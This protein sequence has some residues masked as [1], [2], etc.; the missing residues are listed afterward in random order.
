M[1]RPKLSLTSLSFFR[2]SGSDE[3]V[4]CS[5]SSLACKDAAL[6]TATQAPKGASPH[7]QQSWTTARLQTYDVPPRACV[8]S[9]WEQPCPCHIE[10]LCHPPPTD[11]PISS[12]TRWSWDHPASLPTSGCSS[13]KGPAV[14][15]AKQY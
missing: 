9:L 1:P 3:V 5:R 10:H 4:L 11:Q 14:K 7:V 2:K 12:R 15:H 8:V 6:P 13:L